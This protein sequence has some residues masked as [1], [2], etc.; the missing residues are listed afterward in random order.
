MRYLLIQSKHGYREYPIMEERGC[1]QESRKTDSRQIDVNEI[2]IRKVRN[3]DRVFCLSGERHMFERGENVSISSGEEAVIQ[4]PVLE[5]YLYIRGM[6][7]FFDCKE[8]EN[9]EYLYLNQQRL[10]T[11]ESELCPGDVLFLKNM[12]IEVWKDRVIIWG[13]SGDYT[14]TLREC[15]KIQRPGGFPI[16]KRSPRLMKKPSTERI[17]LEFP[18]EKEKQDRKGF[19]MTVLPSVGMTVVTVA[20]GMITGRGIY[21][22]MSAM[23]T[24]MTAIFSGI[25]YIDEKE[26]L[27]NKNQKQ[28][29]SYRNYLWSKQ[30]EI[31]AAYEWEQEV[32]AYQV[33]GGDELGRMVREYS[34]RIYERVP[35]DEDFLNVS[36]GHCLGQTSFVIEGKEPSWDAGRDKLT[37][38][39]KNIR[40]KYSMI[41]QPKIVDLKKSHLGIVGEKEI[42]CRQLKILTSRIACFQSYHDLRMIV[43]Y[44]KEYEDEFQW[45]RWLPH[46]RIPALNMFGM[47]SSERTR[48][49]VL[50]SMGR[51]LKERAEHL[52]ERE[53]G[54]KG[55]YLP[56]Y[57]FLIQEPSWITDHGIMEY[58]RMEGKEMGFSVIYIGDVRANL[59]EYIGTVLQVENSEEGRLL[60]DAREY[61]NQKIKLYQAQDV[62]FE[63]LA[64]DLSMVEHEQGVTSYIPGNVTFFEMYGIQCPEELEIRRRWKESRSYRSL[65][66]PVGMR[67]AEETM[68]LNLHEKAH[69]PHGLVAGTT[70]SG[71]SE[72]VQSYILS[73]AVN[74]HPHEVGFLL[75]DYKGGGMANMFHKLPHHLGT[76]TNLDGAGSMRAL[77]SVKAELSRRQRI[78]ADFQVNHINGYMRLFKEGEAH[79]PIPHLFIIS[80]E[81]AE[82]KKEQPDFMKE[83]VSAAR[84]GRSLGIHLILATQKPAGIVD[85]Q[86]LSNSR[87]RLCLKVQNESDSKEILKTP[88]AA[89]IT[90]PGRAYIQV[91][92][93]EVYEMFQ[94]AWSGASYRETEEQTR[95]DDERVYVVNEF[96]QG[97]LINQ[98]LSGKKGEYLACMTQ[99]EAVVA[100]IR[101]VFEDEGR[102][103][104]KKP[105]LPPLEEMIVS[106]CA[107]VIR[108]PGMNKLEPELTVSLGITDIPEIQKQKEL[109]HSFV[110]EGNLLFVASAGFGKTVFLTT[111]LMSLAI[112]YDVDDLNYYIL[113]Y[114]NNGCM[115]LKGL[116]HTAEYIALDDKERYWKFK[117]RITEEI[118]IRK[119]LFAGYAAS[120][121]EA[122]QEL[123]GE[124]V[125]VIVI[126]IDQF[127]VV[128]EAGIEEEEFFTKLTRDGAGLGIYTVA[129]A[130]RVTAI[131]QATLNNFN[132]KIAG[133][134]FDEN[135]TF[136]TVGRTAYRQTDKKG[137]VLVGGKNVHEA[138][139]YAMVP[140]EDKTVYGRALKGL[141]QEI[142][143]KYPG[144]EAPH[145]PVLPSEFFVSMMKEYDNDGSSYLVGLEVEE[146]ALKGFERTAG[147]FVIIGNTGI[148]KTNML[149]VL[150]DQ[151]VLRGRVC[152]FDSRSMEMYDYRRFSNVLYIEGKKEADAF[153]EELSGEIES[154]RQFLKEKLCE[155]QGISPKQ[156]IEE[157]PFYTVLID[158]LDDF[159]ELMKGDSERAASLIKE[160]SALGVTC[161]ITVHAA[162]SRGMSAM[163]KLIKQA[164]EGLVLSSQ[165]VVPI[166]PVLAMREYPKSKEGLLFKNGAYQRVRL[167]LHD[168]PGAPLHKNKAPSEE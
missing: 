114:G 104:V 118:T 123:T 25:R 55:N 39:V 57:L 80:D 158:D 126:A 119:R 58:L 122:Y 112:S 68:I 154:R 98:D 66:V 168:F 65:A 3:D 156:L 120:S 1:E 153:V 32:Y 30:R 71:K 76:I 19:L 42:L 147:L 67:S 145:I 46:V 79:E 35:S 13:D 151:A 64:R 89:N 130:N 26:A 157:T 102:A 111:V 165:G 121:W 69:G 37:E 38:N 16:Y 6:R 142:C 78:F 84:I 8:E 139:I 60:L 81:F 72:L 137:R 107:G 166:F 43:I 29:E 36:V 27:K 150:A 87:F 143:R 159:T 125:K 103:E 97:K 134:N 61:K 116:P 148:G 85:E 59:P 50:G 128:R 96:G 135:E 74:F 33:P 141:V 75:I 23:A 70:G 133:Y 49:L 73:L 129:S 149:K 52:K 21:L 24:G 100:H 90:L 22:L 131:R 164:A 113:D 12:K 2:S 28:E 140:C 40:E 91:G 41:D 99:L 124:S 155:N 115:P 45:M 138:Q 110:K 18:K 17:L 136:Q 132:K 9:P 146:V 47:V 56:H 162:K 108:E 77:I 44:D 160:G 34:S 144:R 88:D 62:D 94:S 54:S 117:K 163:D 105:W 48:D 31:A 10:E 101:E 53:K 127:D 4:I 7:Y 15:F 14:T 152:L 82:L 167:P 86:I 92:N 83:L 11:G 93:N 95:T 106:P 5:S 63:W 109:K 20:I 161:I 51:I